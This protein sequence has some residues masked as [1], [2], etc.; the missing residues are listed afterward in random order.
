M[1]HFTKY[2]S[3][4][5][6]TLVVSAP[7][8]ALAATQSGLIPCGN[9][10]KNAAGVIEDKE[11][12]TFDDLIKLAQIIIDFLIF[13]IAA[14]LAAIMFVYAGFLM[15]TNQ[16]NESQIQHGKEVFMNVFIGFVV[17]L[18]AWLLISFI[19]Q[20]LVNPKFNFLTP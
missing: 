14:P 9:G 11:M 17:C 18:A 2:L 3:I 19:L 4:I 12:C 1:K 6:C 5:A 20:F 7:L 10:V 15:V 8:A 16:G 13:K